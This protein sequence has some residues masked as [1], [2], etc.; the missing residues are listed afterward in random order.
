MP[1]LAVVSSV[2]AGLRRLRDTDIARL[3]GEGFDLM[4]LVARQFNLPLCRLKFVMNGVPLNEEMLLSE[5]GLETAKDLGRLQK[6]LFCSA[7][8]SYRHGYWL[9]TQR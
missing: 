9:F 2:A 3:A 6:W 1:D 4:S 7:I 5:L 8:G